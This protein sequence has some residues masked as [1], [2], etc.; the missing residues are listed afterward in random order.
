MLDA[1]LAH[2]KLDTSETYAGARHKACESISDRSR[3]FSEKNF[4]LLSNLLI[5]VADVEFSSLTDGYR[6]MEFSCRCSAV[7][8][9][10]LWNVQFCATK[11]SFHATNHIVINWICCAPVVRLPH[12]SRASASFEANKMCLTCILHWIKS[13]ECTRRRLHTHRTNK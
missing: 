9:M 7:R 11:R 2:V 5:I 6:Q 1:R 13:I 3:W 10:Q 12:A 4:Y 8:T